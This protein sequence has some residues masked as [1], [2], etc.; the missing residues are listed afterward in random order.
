MV[1]S[2]TNFVRFSFVSSAYHHLG[3]FAV[4]FQ[5]DNSHCQTP[6]NLEN[7]TFYYNGSCPYFDGDTI[8]FTCKEGHTLTSPHSKIVCR[9]DG[10]WNDSLPMCTNSSFMPGVTST[11]TTITNYQHNTTTV[12]MVTTTP[13]NTPSTSFV[14]AGTVAGAV[15]GVIILMISFLL[16]SIMIYRRKS[17][18]EKH[19]ENEVSYTTDRANGDTGTSQHNNSS[20]VFDNISCDIR[21]YE[22]VSDAVTRNNQVGVTE[23]KLQREDLLI[24]RTTHSIVKK[25]MQI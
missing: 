15:I 3:K 6:T 22:E 4:T 25:G 16:V 2:C 12:E 7:S 1:V 24:M 17:I 21:N 20:N 14:D 11:Q 10:T 8:T 9:E 19:A 23:R 13:K 5:A 18:S